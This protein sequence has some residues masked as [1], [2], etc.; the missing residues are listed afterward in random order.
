VPQPEIAIDC[1]V[2]RAGKQHVER[3]DKQQYGI[4]HADI[5][6]S[7]HDFHS[8]LP[9]GAP[10]CLAFPFSFPVHSVTIFNLIAKVTLFS[11]TNRISMLIVPNKAYAVLH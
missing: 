7:E 1:Y 10:A 11:K 9:E 8:P 6:G 4:P 3:H 5:E 2:S